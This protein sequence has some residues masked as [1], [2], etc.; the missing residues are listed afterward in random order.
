A[1]SALPGEVSKIRT[2]AVQPVFPSFAQAEVLM[3]TAAAHRKPLRPR[4]MTLK[5][6]SS[7]ANAANSN[8]RV[9]PVLEIVH[10]CSKLS[11][12]ERKSAAT[13]LV[14]VAPA[15]NIRSAAA[16]TRS[17]LLLVQRRIPIY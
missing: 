5:R 14:P 17:G 2:R 12:A 11:A 8:K 1:R 4:L 13:I 7:D 10:P 16:R 9:W 6:H 3:E 15:R